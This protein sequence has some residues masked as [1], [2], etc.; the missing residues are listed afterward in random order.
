MTLAYGGRKPSRAE[1]A[2]PQARV[3]RAEARPL[4]AVYGW[5]I[6]A[7]VSGLLWLGVAKLIVA[8]VH[9]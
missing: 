1:A 6:A 8:L 4:P 7:L 9:I 3:R 5:M 2:R